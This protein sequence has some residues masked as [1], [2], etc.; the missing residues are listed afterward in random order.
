MAPLNPRSG[1]GYV[2][3]LLVSFA[4][5]DRA[6]A[7]FLHRRLQGFGRSVRLDMVD[8]RR[9]FSGDPQQYV[10]PIHSSMVPVV[11]AVLG[12]EYGLM[13]WGLLV[14][15]SLPKSG[16]ATIVPIWSLEI[17]SAELARVSNSVGLSFDPAGDLNEQAGQVAEEIEKLLVQRDQRF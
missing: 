3:D 16:Y 7:Q 10:A 6:F 13:R 4:A 11:V 2:E 5:E 15:S 9:I 12:C 14:S 8:E 17:P 1:P